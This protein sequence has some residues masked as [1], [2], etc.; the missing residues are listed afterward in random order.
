[1]AS[2]ACKYECAQLVAYA[3][4]VEYLG[5]LGFVKTMSVALLSRAVATFDC[6]SSTVMSEVMVD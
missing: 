5:V 4:L 3:M 2:Y 1:M 6:M